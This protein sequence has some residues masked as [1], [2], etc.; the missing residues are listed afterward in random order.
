MLVAG[1]VAQSTGAGAIQSNHN[2]NV[3]AEIQSS[4]LH[5][6]IPIPLMRCH[7]AQYPASRPICSHLEA[8]VHI[9]AQHF[10]VLFKESL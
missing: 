9:L 5:S 1:S 2:S 10:V 8:L 4:R 7:G 3:K 6:K